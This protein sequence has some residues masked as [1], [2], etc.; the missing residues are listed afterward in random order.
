MSY[1]DSSHMSYAFF[2]KLKEEIKTKARASNR[3]WTEVC[4]HYLAYLHTKEPSEDGSDEGSDMG[5]QGFFMWRPMLSWL[6]L[7]STEVCHTKRSA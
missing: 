2:H 5:I 3:E 4:M 1:S 6:G 7:I